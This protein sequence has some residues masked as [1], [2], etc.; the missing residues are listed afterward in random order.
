[1]NNSRGVERGCTYPSTRL[2]KAESIPLAEPSTELN[3]TTRGSVNT[4]REH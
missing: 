3:L 2:T 4:E 1:M